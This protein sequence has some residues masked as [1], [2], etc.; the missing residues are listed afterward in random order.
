MLYQL[1]LLMSAGN[2]LLNVVERCP[3]EQVGPAIILQI[4]IRKGGTPAILIQ[5]SAVYLS[6]HK[7]IPELF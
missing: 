1:H 5:F 4:S 2:V 7:E 6:P 3:D